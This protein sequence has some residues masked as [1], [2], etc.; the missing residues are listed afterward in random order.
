MKRLPQG[1]GSALLA[2]L[3]F[4]AGTPLA[5]RLL[6][7]PCTARRRPSERSYGS[8]SEIAIDGADPEVGD[9]RPSE[10]IGAVHLVG[11]DVTKPVLAGRQCAGRITL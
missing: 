3:F 2:A 7:T 4:G 9:R 8:P 11:R 10:A 5:K 6:D 1:V